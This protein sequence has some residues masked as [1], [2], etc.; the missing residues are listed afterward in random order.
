M[1]LPR[2]PVPP[3]AEAFELL[4][5]QHATAL[6]RQAFLLC[7][8]HGTAARAVAH[9]FRRA[10]ERWPEV[11]VDPD[12]AGWVRAAAHRYAL[13]PWRPS[14]LLS[15][16]RHARAVRRAPP[17]DRALVDALLRLPP[18]YRAALLLHDGLG[19]GLAAT[20]AEVEA[21]T[22]AA[23]GRVRHA[24]AALAAGVP[25]LRSAPPERRGEL[26]ATRLGELAAPHPV[27]LP[28]ARLVRRRGTRRSWYVTAA[29]A[30]LVGAVVTA[31]VC[32]SAGYGPGGSWDV[33]PPPVPK[34]PGATL[35]PDRQ[36]GR[37]LP[38]R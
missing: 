9:A 30:G 35:P 2:R 14:R 1:R 31:V 18:S 27:P 37:L 24:R 34:Q 19:I 6:A 20:A 17:G 28:A 10:W 36:P 11:A 29:G 22:R 23:E 38:M 8:H 3:A 16:R 12:P 32:V 21:G 4:H 13:A 15:P 26:I 7:G 25:E 33:R 5:E